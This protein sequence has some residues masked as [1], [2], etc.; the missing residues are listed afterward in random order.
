MSFFR[1]RASTPAGSI[2]LATEQDHAALSRFVHI[3]DQRFLT[4]DIVDVAKLFQHDPTALREVDGRVTAALSFGWRTTPVAWLRT[5]L[6]R[7]DDETGATLRALSDPLH[8]VLRSDGIHFVAITL[9]EWHDPWLR[10]P[11]QQLGYRPM[12]QVIGYEKRDLSYPAAGNRIVA[13]RRA[14]PDDLAGI[15]ELDRLCFP[16]PWVK[17]AEILAPAVRDSPCFIVATFGEQIVGYAYV[18]GHHGGRLFHLVRIA[19]APSVQGRGIGVRLLAEVVDYCASQYAELLT[20]NTQSDNR[21]AQRLY[22]WFGFTRTGDRQTVLGCD[23][24]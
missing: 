10:R 20:L 11:L 21:Q 1:R 4:S 14:Q 2:R 23:I 17:G 7:E 12:V 15:L 6:L 5:F 22:E 16:L 19:V 18:T 9:D 3:A 24:G 8:R 13:V